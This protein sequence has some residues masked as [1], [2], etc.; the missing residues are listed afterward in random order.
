MDLP[1][2]D[3]THF[4]LTLI[5][6]VCLIFL[7][8][9]GI[10]KVGLFSGMVVKPL[11]N[12]RIRILESQMIDPKNKMILVRWDEQETL[13]MIGERCSLVIDSKKGEQRADGDQRE[14]LDIKG[15]EG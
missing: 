2:I 11:K 3:Y 10:K 4:A 9:W 13:M 12:R 8:S 5:A 7:L 6:V 15:G 14:A 1:V